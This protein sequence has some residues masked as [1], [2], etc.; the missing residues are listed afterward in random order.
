MIQKDGLCYQVNLQA[1]RLLQLLKFSIVPNMHAYA[2][3]STTKSIR[4][5]WYVLRMSNAKR[6]QCIFTPIVNI[7]ANHIII[8]TKTRTVVCNQLQSTPKRGPRWLLRLTQLGLQSYNRGLDCCIYIE[9]EPNRR[10]CQF[11]VMLL[12]LHPNN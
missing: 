12:A 3:A 8:G 5:K 4:E 2:Q 6:I 1:F 10:G 11:G 7:I 9:T